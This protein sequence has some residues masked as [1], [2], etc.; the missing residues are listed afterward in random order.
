MAT[1]DELL[2]D[3]TRRH[4]ALIDSTV[5]QFDRRLQPILA[6]AQ[7]RLAEELRGELTVG[8]GGR[9]I[10]DARTQR[11]LRA[12]RTRFPALMAAEGYDKLLESLSASFGRQIPLFEEVLDILGVPKPTWR[13]ADRAFFD[14]QARA[15]VVTL[16]DLVDGVG[17]A[18]YRTALLQIGGLKPARLAVL[19]ANETGKTLPQASAIADTATTVF[20]RTIAARG[21][22]IIEA[23]GA[24]HFWYYGPKDKL[25]RPFCRQ[26]LEANRALTRADISKLRNP[27]GTDVFTQAGGYRCRHQWILAKAEK[28]SKP[29]PPPLDFGDKAKSEIAL[30]IGTLR[31]KWKPTIKADPDAYAAVRNYTASSIAYNSFLRQGLRPEVKLAVEKMVRAFTWKVE[32]AILT[33]RGLIKTDTL[34]GDL[35]VDRAFLST[36][37]DA[38]VANNFE[39]GTVARILLRPGQAA[40]PIDGDS[41]YP[42]EHEIILPPGTRLRATGRTKV[43]VDGKDLEV[44]DFEVEPL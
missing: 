39:S 26:I 4:N 3:H 44:I 15:G 40:V 28:P 38:R 19:L 23:D 35:L 9:I 14:A 30:Y 29:E 16:S 36:T 11:A 12:I 37:L 13:A 34:V 21:Y 7:A 32:E 10:R 8:T 18:T 33:Y 20:Y 24:L 43:R 5:A 17:G 42:Q 2:D 27:N 41:Q 25:N 6:R 1:I 31:D 22:E